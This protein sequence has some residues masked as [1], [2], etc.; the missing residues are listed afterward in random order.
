MTALPPRYCI[1][2]GCRNLTPR[3]RCE[4][5]QA[6]LPYKTEAWRQIRKQ[7]L[8]APCVKCGQPA[9]H[10]NHIIPLRE[11]GTNDMDN[12]EALCQSHHNQVTARGG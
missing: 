1:V 6:E 10:I 9:S 4:D 8:P 5:H 2:Q 7:I 3:S 11:G 12:L